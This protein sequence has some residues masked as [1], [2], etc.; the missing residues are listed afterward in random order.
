LQQHSSDEA[1]N[2]FTPK[3]FSRGAKKESP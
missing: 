3:M 2:P 1:A